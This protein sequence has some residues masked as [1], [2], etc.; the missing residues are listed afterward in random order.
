MGRGGGGSEDEEDDGVK[1]GFSGLFYTGRVTSGNGLLP[2]WATGTGMQTTKSATKE[3][4]WRGYERN[5]TL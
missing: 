1:M 2:I 5:R 3:E 4:A